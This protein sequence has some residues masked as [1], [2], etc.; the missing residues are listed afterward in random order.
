MKF[1]EE[2][3]KKLI[4]ESCSKVRVRVIQL[5]QKMKMSKNLE[6]NFGWEFQNLETFLRL[7]NLSVFSFYAM[8]MII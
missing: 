5:K 3:D 4:M 7:A 1:G 2:M 8:K 6:H